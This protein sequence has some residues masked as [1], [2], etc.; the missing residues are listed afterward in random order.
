MKLRSSRSEL[1][2][3]KA[4]NRR[5]TKRGRWVHPWSWRVK[6]THLASLRA[7]QQRTAAASWPW[8]S[9][10]PC[11]KTNVRQTPRSLSLTRAPPSSINWSQ[12]CAP[13]KPL[14]SAKITRKRRITAT[15]RWTWNWRISTHSG[16][17]CK[18]SSTLRSS[19]SAPRQTTKTNLRMLRQHSRLAMADR[20]S[21]V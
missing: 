12:R 5:W 11:P 16:W 18:K 21:V 10:Q 17:I 4:N 20:K 8:K 19:D 9:A 1:S 13:S 3:A 2:L 15:T 14:R 7:L 6:E